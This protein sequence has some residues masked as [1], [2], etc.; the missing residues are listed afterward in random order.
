ML[1]GFVSDGSRVPKTIFSQVLFFSDESHGTIRNPS[2]KSPKTT[3]IQ[4]FR[5]VKCSNP[6]ALKV[7]KALAVKGMEVTSVNSRWKAP[8]NPKFSKKWRVSRGQFED[9]TLYRKKN[10]HQCF[11]QMFFA[12][13][14]VKSQDTSRPFS[15]QMKWAHKSILMSSIPPGK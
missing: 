14:L 10:M 7:F 3:Q 12:D 13:D 8:W 5:S 11:L 6:W 2:T 4:G 1:L 15:K 9:Y